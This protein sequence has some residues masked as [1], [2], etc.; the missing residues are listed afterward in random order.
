[1]AANSF[2]AVSLRYD[3]TLDRSILDIELPAD[4]AVAESNDSQATLLFSGYDALQSVTL[5]ADQMAD[6]TSGGVTTLSLTLPP[7]VML[8]ASP[9]TGPEPLRISFENMFGVVQLDAAWLIQPDDGAGMVFAPLTI[10]DRETA[11]TDQM[12]WVAADADASGD[13]NLAAGEGDDLIFMGDGDSVVNGGDGDDRVILEVPVDEFDS[14]VSVR[15]DTTADLLSLTTD[16]GVALYQIE[17]LLDGADGVLGV[18]IVRLDDAGSSTDSLQAENIEAIEVSGMMD[19]LL[20]E[21]RVDWGDGS[22]SPTLQGTPW[23]DKFDLNQFIADTPDNDY[24]SLSAGA[25]FDTASYR[26]AT[27]YDALQLGQDGSLS[28]VLDG[29][30]EIVGYLNGGLQLVDNTGTYKTITVN[31]YDYNGDQLERLELMSG[32]QRYVVD[33]IASPITMELD[34]ASTDPTA[35]PADLPVK[36]VEGDGDF[37]LKSINAGA[38][39][40]LPAGATLVAYVAEDLA[41]ADP[42]GIG[43]GIYLELTD[44]SGDAQVLELTMAGE[45]AGA[46]VAFDLL[47]A[48]GTAY[49]TMIDALDVAGSFNAAGDAD[50]GNKLAMLPLNSPPPAGDPTIEFDNDTRFLSEDN[51]VTTLINPPDDDPAV[52]VVPYDDGVID[53]SVSYWAFKSITS[54]SGS[55]IFSDIAALDGVDR[56]SFE[57]ADLELDRLVIENAVSGSDSESIQHYSDTD[58]NAVFNLYIDQNRGGDDVDGYTFDGGTLIATGSNLQVE[59]I[60]YTDPNSDRYGEADGWLSLD[61]T[62]VAGDT[63][64]SALIAELEQMSEDENIDGSVNLRF[65]IDAFDPLS[66]QPFINRAVENSEIYAISGALDLGGAAPAEPMPIFTFTPWEGATLQLFDREGEDGTIDFAT[67]VETWQNSDGVPE[68]EQTD[69][70]ISWNAA[71]PGAWQAAYTQVIEFNDWDVTGRPISF[72]EDGESV[73]V[74]W[75]SETAADGVVATS[76]WQA[77]WDEDGDGIDEEWSSQ[78]DFIDKD[79]DTQPDELHYNSTAIQSSDDLALSASG[80]FDLTLAQDADDKIVSMTLVATS[81]SGDNGEIVTGMAQYDADGNLTDFGWPQPDDDSSEPNIGNSYCN[82]DA[83]PIENSDLSSYN[84]VNFGY[85][86]TAGTYTTLDNMDGTQMSAP[87]AVNAQRAMQ[88]FVTAAQD[89]GYGLRI[90]DFEDAAS[91]N[92]AGSSSSYVAASGQMVND[93]FGDMSMGTAEGLLTL[94]SF[95]DVRLYNTGDA[96]S[97]DPNNGDDPGV[98]TNAG[99]DADRGFNTTITAGADHYLEVLPGNNTSGGVVLDFSNS[100]GVTGFGLFL[101]GREADKREVYVEITLSDG[102]GTTSTVVKLLTPTHPNGQ[103]GQQF[104]GYQLDGV[105]AEGSVIEQVVLCE[106][107]DVNNPSAPRDIFAIDDILLMVDEADG[108]FDPVDPT[109]GISGYVNDYEPI[110]G[111]AIANLAIGLDDGDGDTTNNLTT[112]TDENGHFMFASAHSDDRFYVVQS[113]D[114]SGAITSDDALAALKLAAGIDPDSDGANDG[115]QRMMADV[116]GD[117]RVTSYDALL[118]LKEALNSGDGVDYTPNFHLVDHAMAN[119]SSR[120]DVTPIDS[121]VMVGY[122][123]DIELVGVVSGDVDGSWSAAAASGV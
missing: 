73:A 25:G 115:F 54:G 96:T 89:G 66:D 71:E 53:G 35:A 48:D 5:N 52:I 23:E 93:Q 45:Y 2:G 21:V 85:D 111:V 67:L 100:G 59:T 64:G 10:V 105:A 98:A 68:Q 76:S 27:A 79:G 114:T 60:T 117:G 61:L 119:S 58:N 84:L 109:D 108:N 92:F 99:N 90:Y 88:A 110:D 30:S 51:T 1:M 74:T 44:E 113:V 46:A 6:A 82:P 57:V 121:G 43:I 63:T 116:D 65:S 3:E 122:S 75:M 41:V 118:I 42:P 32:D 11:G 91:G 49:R 36:L 72:L 40:T 13:V 15:V 120:T 83:I 7:E 112:T 37:S 77:W 106:P 38:T 26:F 28:G 103:G 101:M 55:L 50:N 78:V 81:A 17:R 24:L 18:D 34:G 47:M 123:S 62:T 16:S 94:D 86:P 33:L 8:E 80:T 20:I 107:Y 56:L 87:S 22:S 9:T 31:N 29:N 14:P 12:D 104:I 97:S 4:W 19:P 39:A 95:L 102:A 70:I 69:Y